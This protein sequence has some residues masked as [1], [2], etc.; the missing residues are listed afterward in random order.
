MSFLV[1]SVFIVICSSFF[2]FNYDFF[3][4]IDCSVELIPILIILRKNED[5]SGG[6]KYVMWNQRN[7]CSEV[8]N[9]FFWLPWPLPLRLR[10]QI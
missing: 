7:F 2:V 3:I 1:W 8:R 4:P 5:K 10:D 6:D 9:N